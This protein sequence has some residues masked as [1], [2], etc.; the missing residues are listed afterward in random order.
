M[1]C[2]RRCL[3]ALHP[4]YLFISLPIH[5][6]I[7]D[8]YRLNE[9]RGKWMRGDLHR[10]AIKPQ[11]IPLSLSLCHPPFPSPSSC[12]LNRPLNHSAQA[13]WLVDLSAWLN[14]HFHHILH[15][16][17]TEWERERKRE[18]NK[19]ILEVSDFNQMGYLHVTD[20]HLDQ[21][22]RR[23]QQAGVN[24]TWKC[25]TCC[26]YYE[27]RAEVTTR[28]VGQWTATISLIMTTSTINLLLIHFWC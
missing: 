1:A 7:R 23:Q 11:P 12:A 21:R 16:R 22:S 28:S 17:V 10:T 9:T 3:L 2:E 24:S 25:N 5:Q 19:L 8:N 13:L 4:L 15:R 27:P 20:R 6:S 26:E 14:S 18:T